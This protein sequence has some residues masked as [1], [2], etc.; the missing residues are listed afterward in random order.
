M[1]IK[2]SVEKGVVLAPKADLLVSNVSGDILI[3]DGV[4]TA[5]GISGETRGSSTRGGEL[6]IG[7][8]HDNPLFH[9]DLPLEADLSELPAVLDHLE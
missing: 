8:P 5:T 4:L 7:L 9:L 2:C 6:T 1:I 3:K